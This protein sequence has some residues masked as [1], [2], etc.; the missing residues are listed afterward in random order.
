MTPT[1]I[2]EITQLRSRNVSPKQIARKLGL[3][4]AEVSAIIRQQSEAGKI[5]KSLPEL[6]AIFINGGAARTLLNLSDS[7]PSTT[8]SDPQGDEAGS[9]LA[10]IIMLRVDEKAHHWVSSYLIDYW[11]LGLKNTFGPRQMT[12]KQ[13]DELLWDTE[14][15]F[16]QSLQEI[17]LEQAQAVIF[18]AIDYAQRLGF[19]PHSDFRRS[20][21][22]LGPRAKTLIDIPCGKDGM[23]FFMAGPYDNAAQIMATLRESVGEGNFN[24]LVG[25]G[26]PFDEFFYN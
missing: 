2:E 26:S 20:R 12:R 22:H 15:R 24:S 11:C 4:P 13:L 21:A 14:E 5:Q 19:E 6:Q 3:R 25:L 17:S 18:G 16:E 1:Q 8:A 23:P 7:M 9:G 10:Q